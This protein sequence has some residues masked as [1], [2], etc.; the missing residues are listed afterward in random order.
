MDKLE[1]YY[2]KVVFQ[3]SI[4]KRQ[5]KENKVVE[6]KMNVLGMILWLKQQNFEEG[7]ELSAESWG[8][9]R[10]EKMRH[11]YIIKFFLKMF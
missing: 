8:V 4:L 10:K 1:K 11:I 7:I 9:K 6:V 2:D 3:M 5:V